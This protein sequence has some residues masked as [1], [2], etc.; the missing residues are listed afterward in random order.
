[1][2]ASRT[3]ASAL[4]A[5]LLLCA[6]TAARAQS[7]VDRQR[8]TNIGQ[9]VADDRVPTLTLSTNGRGEE[10]APWSPGSADIGEQR[11]L[12]RQENYEAF[13]LSA[14]LG[15][16]LTDNVAL[17]S[18][19]EEEDAF[20]V[21]TLVAAWRPRLTRRLYGEVSLTQ[22]IYRYDEFGVLDFESLEPAVGL[23]YLSDWLGGMSFGARYTFTRYT[24][25]DND[26]FNETH[27]LALAAQKP[28]VYSRGLWFYIGAG[29]KI[30]LATDP[31]I[32]R[33]HEYGIQLGMNASL[34]RWLELQ[35][36]ARSSVFDYPEYGR[37]DFN[38]IVGANLNFKA[39]D[40]VT[41]SLFASAAFNRSD[42]DVFDYDVFNP[43]VG[44]A[45]NFRF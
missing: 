10:F 39:C 43:G 26:A 12:K 4:L 19:G 9:N 33:R 28:F 35:I 11:I 38:Q 29:A 21:A 27:A 32:A 15:A 1:M 6:V 42:E 8:L 5:A 44:L 25:G 17:V 34:A 16:Y 20:L 45:L 40:E 41:A 37:A 14:G 7:P 30:A 31:E 3:A 18:A 13:S 23:A 22:Q 2:P 36:Y 24:A